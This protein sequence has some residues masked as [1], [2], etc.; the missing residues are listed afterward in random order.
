MLF[1]GIF[2]KGWGCEKITKEGILYLVNGMQS[3][4]TFIDETIF[5][6]FH[7]TMRSWVCWT[8]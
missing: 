1:Q 5:S 6:A 8:Q 3:A 7:L 2:L 4:L